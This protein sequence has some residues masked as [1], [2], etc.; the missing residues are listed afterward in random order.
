VGDPQIGLDHRRVV[1]HL[2]GRAVGQKLAVV[3]HHD[4][5]RDVHDH[6]HV[7]LDQRDR[8]AELLVD[9]EHEAAHVLLLLEVH[10]G[11]RLIEQQELRLHRQRPAE[12]DPL[13]H[14][15]GQAAHGRVADRLDL[16]EIDDLLDERAVRQLLAPGATE[17]DRL[18]ERGR[19][20]LEDAAGHQIV[21][22]GH[23]PE[24]GD[25]LEGAPDAVERGLMRAHPALRLA[26]VGDGALLGLI[27]AVDDVEHRRLAGAVGP[28]DRPDLALHDVEADAG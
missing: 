3:E 28:D 21:E 20:H 6:A 7:V 10:P 23:A 18:L 17:I 19:L 26:L 2:V 1:P 4:P 14:A 12:L 5:V 15:V 16:E 13:L 8:G 11:H 22:R 24:Q 9:V 25:V 27:E